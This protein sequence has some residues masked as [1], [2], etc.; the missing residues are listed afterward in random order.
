VDSNDP[1]VGK[2]QA[3]LE[4]IRQD[5]R[6]SRVALFAPSGRGLAMLAQKD[7]DQTGLDIAHACWARRRGE[8]DAGRP[9]LY[10]CALLWPLFDGPAPAAL[11]YLDRAR[12]GFP[13]EA[14][15]EDAARLLRIMTKIKVGSPVAAYLDAGIVGSAVL[16]SFLADQLALALQGA[17]GS[18]AGAARTLGIS[19]ETVYER[20]DRFGIDLEAFRPRRRG[21]PRRK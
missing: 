16:D 19:R 6:A 21:H 9:F 11:L 7:I 2:L 17:S 4:L 18:V 20:A 5:A 3:L 1:H 15:R 10:G 8:I 14:A 12:E 13:D